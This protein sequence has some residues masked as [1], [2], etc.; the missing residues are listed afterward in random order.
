MWTPSHSR[1]NPVSFSAN[2]TLDVLLNLPPLDIE[3]AIEI[4]RVLLD[5]LDGV[6]SDLVLSIHEIELFTGPVFFHAGWCGNLGFNVRKFPH[7]LF[8]VDD[9]ISASLLDENG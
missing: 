3:L 4:L 1:D 2:S 5:R 9:R 8:V 6:L 7:Y